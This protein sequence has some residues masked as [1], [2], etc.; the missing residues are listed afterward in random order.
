[1]NG[2]WSFASFNLNS[3]F[4][5]PLH[6]LR[7]NNSN[8]C[9]C[10]MSAGNLVY[11]ASKVQAQR[12]QGPLAT[13][14]PR[15]EKARGHIVSVM[16]PPSRPRPRSPNARF[17]TFFEAGTPDTAAK[18]TLCDQHIQPTDLQRICDWER[19]C[20]PTLC[21]Y[22]MGDKRPW[23]PPPPIWAP[24]TFPEWPSGQPTPQRSPSTPLPWRRL[25]R[26][27]QLPCGR[28]KNLD[29]YFTPGSPSLYSIAT[30]ETQPQSI[31]KK[32]EIRQLRRHTPVSTLTAVLRKDTVARNL[33]GVGVLWSRG[34]KREL[35]PKEEQE[36]EHKLD[37]RTSHDFLRE[38]LKRQ[39]PEEMFKRDFSFGPRATE[40]KQ[41]DYQSPLSPQ[42][43]CSTSPELSPELDHNSLKRP[44]HDSSNGN[45]EANSSDR[46]HSISSPIPIRGSQP[47]SS[48][49]WPL[50]TGFEV[51]DV[52][53]GRKVDSVAPNA[54][55]IVCAIG[56]H[57]GGHMTSH[58]R[59]SDNMD[60]SKG[61]N[62]YF[63]HDIKDQH[64]SASPVARPSYCEAC[65]RRHFATVS[66]QQGEFRYDPGMSY[67]ATDEKFEMKT[68]VLQRRP[69]TTKDHA[70]VLGDATTG[71]ATGLWS[72]PTETPPLSPMVKT[73]QSKRT[74]RI[75]RVARC[76]SSDAF[77]RA[78]RESRQARTRREMGEMKGNGIIYRGES[79]EER[80][81]IGNEPL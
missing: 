80:D 65:L 53:P 26:R 2:P 30:P 3:S 6:T 79:E 24:A 55:D 49:S 25:R 81:W 63:S 50:T 51:P 39:Q 48:V 56:N 27:P 59:S 1:M 74:H 70:S 77:L 16:A 35:R 14:Q 5:T 66:G 44:R 19:G 75:S 64:A 52:H 67:R 17:Q 20:P 11:T 60:E 68:C 54:P 40:D 58:Y 42:S 9:T 8:V 18:I 43:S 15:S 78:V 34:K 73:A 10:S 62:H 76:P 41:D 37:R 31:R 45:A 7:L 69:R 4:W 72:T 22:S 21:R 61:C 32:P 33:R 47:M 46:G 13:S 23:R 28:F 29:L 57:R 12:I 71:T 36:Q 38:F